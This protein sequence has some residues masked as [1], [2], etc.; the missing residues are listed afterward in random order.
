[1]EELRASEVDFEAVREG[2]CVGALSLM[3]IKGD[4]DNEAIILFFSVR[5]ATCFRLLNQ[6]RFRNTLQ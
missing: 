2:E 3:D 1:V 4:A 6:P 5:F